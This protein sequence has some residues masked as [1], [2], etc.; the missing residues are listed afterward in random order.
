[1]CIAFPGRVVQVGPSDAV[2]D[3]GGRSRRA[4]L[5]LEPHVEVD[6]WVLV[7]AGTVV[8]RLDAREAADLADLLRP[9]M[10][11]GGLR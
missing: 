9:A 4:S 8:R 5:L 11:T 1:M 3:I 10:T 7:A 2:V 6:D